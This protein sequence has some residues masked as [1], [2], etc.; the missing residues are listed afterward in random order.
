MVST[1]ENCHSGI[2]LIQVGKVKI[3]QRFWP[4]NDIMDLQVEIAAI[5][6]QI[7]SF[8]GL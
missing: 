6:I 7:L 5:A 2:N 4:C 3:K 1:L 8:N